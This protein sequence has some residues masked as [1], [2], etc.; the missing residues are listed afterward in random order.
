MSP[1]STEMAYGQRGAVCPQQVKSE[2]RQ[3]K[4]NVVTEA[5][6]MKPRELVSGVGILSSRKD[7]HAKSRSRVGIPIH[8]TARY[9]EGDAYICK[10]ENEGP[11]FGYENKKPQKIHGQFSSYVSGTAP[12]GNMGVLEDDMAIHPVIAGTI[13]IDE[14][15]YHTFVYGI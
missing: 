9:D 5:R 14:R 2:P 8:S 3:A 15:Y 4:T 11:L 1:H 7:Q 10:D 13:C 12:V 6:I